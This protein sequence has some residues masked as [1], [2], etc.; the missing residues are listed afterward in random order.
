MRDLHKSSVLGSKHSSLMSWRP[1]Y[2]SSKFRNVY[3]KVASREHCFDGIP[4]TKNVHDN[5]FC[6]VN[7]RFL[8]IVTESAG[9]GSFLVIPLEQT[10]RIEP[11]YPKVCGHQGNVLDIK[12][13][14]FIENIIASCSE[15]T[16]VRI[17]EIPEG[18]LKRNMTEAVLELYGHSRRVGLV[19]WHPTTNNILFSAGYDYKVLIWNLDIG[20]PVKMIDCHTDVILCMSFNTDGSLLATT[21]KDKKLRVV[22]PRSGRVLQEASCKNH[23]V[24]RVVFLGSTKRLLTTGVSRWN[25]R[26]I[27]LWDQ[28]DLSMPLIEEEIDGLSGLLFPFYDADTHMLYLAGKGDGNIRYY[29]IGSEKPYLSYLMEF[30]SPAPQKGLGVMPKHGLDV[31]ACEV[32]RFYKLVTL[33]GLIEPISMIVPRRSETYQEDIYPMTPGTEP[34]LT[35]DEWLSGV[36]RDPILM[37][38]KEG[39]RRTSKIVFK[40]PVREKKSVVVNGIDL[41][42]NVPPRTENELLRMFFRQQDEIRRLKDELSQ[43]D[44]RIRQLQLELKNLRNSPKNN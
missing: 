27:A 9:G 13:N 42:E 18:G 21:C 11:N 4:I 40:A 28:E 25:T 16:S 31:S 23:R 10:G 6:A 20:E 35:P 44:I 29:E 38:L 5:H 43:K 7:A 2:R 15:D 30:R 19:E 22:E 17:W 34:A 1:Q 8:A 33:K 41:L 37:S 14:P 36:N 39:Y 32:F 24:N 12:W 3:G 26:Q